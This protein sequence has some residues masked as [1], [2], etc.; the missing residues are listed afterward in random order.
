MRT[1]VPLSAINVDGVMNYVLP[2]NV[3]NIATAICAKTPPRR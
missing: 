2:L 3:V 1:Y